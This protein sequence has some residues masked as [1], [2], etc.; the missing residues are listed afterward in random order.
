MIHI[1]ALKKSVTL[2]LPFCSEYALNKAFVNIQAFMS[3][4]RDTGNWVTKASC[5]DGNW[6]YHT[7]LQCPVRKKVLQNY[8]TKPSCRHGNWR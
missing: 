5:R 6:L 3:W 8:S 1:F 7:S 2:H 4:V